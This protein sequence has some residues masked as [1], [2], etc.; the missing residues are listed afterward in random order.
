MTN[1]RLDLWHG[2]GLL[3]LLIFLVG[4]QHSRQIRSELRSGDDVVLR[5][6]RQKELVIGYVTEE[7]PRPPLGRNPI[8]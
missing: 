7:A 3:S 1:R 4:E 6:K 2:S 5:K 8:T